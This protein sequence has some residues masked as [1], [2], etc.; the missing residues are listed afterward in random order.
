MSTE[1]DEDFDARIDAEFDR[2]RKEHSE[3][4]VKRKRGDLGSESSDL[5]RQKFDSGKSNSTSLDPEG[6]ID[7]RD[8]APASAR[9]TTTTTTTT[10][11]QTAPEAT[12]ETTETE[13]PDADAD[14]NAAAR[15]E[16]A[17]VH[18]RAQITCPCTADGCDKACDTAYTRRYRT[19][20]EHIDS[21]DVLR[22]GLHQRF[23]QRCS[24]FHALAAF[25]G[26]RHTCRQALD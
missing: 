22:D 2:A 23:C 12:T 19:C 3:E 9:P 11:T 24:S 4:A 8:D 14:A 16:L 25:D 21:L 18:P 6:G 10:H 5:E 1:G 7:A 20:R 13:T 15:T 26:S 17:R